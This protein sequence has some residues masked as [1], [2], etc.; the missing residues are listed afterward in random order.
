MSILHWLGI[1][2]IL[3]V[4][5]WTGETIQN[6]TERRKDKEAIR[7]IRKCGYAVRNY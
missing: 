4:F 2:I 3:C 1:L 6:A 7:M 5:T